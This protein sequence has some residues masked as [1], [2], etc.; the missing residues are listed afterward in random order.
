LT[1]FFIANVYINVTLMWYVCR[2]CVMCTKWSWQ[3]SLVSLWCAQLLRRW[4]R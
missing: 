1:P 2:S 4:R 3:C